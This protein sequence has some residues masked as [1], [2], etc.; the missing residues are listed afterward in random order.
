[1][2]TRSEDN[3]TC[4]I[5]DGLTF[6]SKVELCEHQA[7][8]HNKTDENILD[9]PIKVEEVDEVQPA[10]TTTN[11]PQKIGNPPKH[12]IKV[13]TVCHTC[14]SN[15]NE[16]E[17]KQLL[18]ESSNTVNDGSACLLC[19]KQMK[20]A[21]K[22]AMQVVHTKNKELKY[23]CPKCD[24]GFG[25]MSEL[26][27]HISAAHQ[28]ANASKKR[29]CPHCSKILPNSQ[30]DYHIELHNQPNV[31]QYECEVCKWVFFS[32]ST[33]DSHKKAHHGM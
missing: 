12:K 1:M 32:S 21:K 17:L 25:E 16:T 5:C 9:V 18:R 8:V 33:L 13:C 29:V 11:Q 2:S 23:K 19:K 27:A 26:S 4:N 24:K 6:G 10:P 22:M 31:K 7:E 15:V 3:Y 14:V 28:P 20:G 30:Y